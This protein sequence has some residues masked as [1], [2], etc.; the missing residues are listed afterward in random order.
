MTVTIQTSRADDKKQVRKYHIARYMNG[1]YRADAI[2]A[3]RL[4]WIAHR[5]EMLD[6]QKACAAAGDREG[7]K[8]FKGEASE[9]LKLYRSAC[10]VLPYFMVDP[11]K[12]CPYKD[13]WDWPEELFG[14][15]DLVLGAA[16]LVA[17]VA[18]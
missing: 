2:N 13:E 17:E 12:D 8:F 14:H 11:P 9:A 3:Q 1:Y 15:I 10:L 4:R 18:P 6:Y 16:E 5:N 7:A